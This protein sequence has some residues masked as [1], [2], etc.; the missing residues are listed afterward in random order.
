MYPR[1]SNVSEC[2]VCTVLIFYNHRHQS[3]ALVGIPINFLQ[4]CPTS[5]NASSLLIDRLTSASNLL[6]FLFCSRHNEYNI[7]NGKLSL[8]FQICVFEVIYRLHLVIDYT[9]FVQLDL[10]FYCTLC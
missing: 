5:V 4:R 7:L 8:V 9:H 10:L 6:V 3:N 2:C 1:K